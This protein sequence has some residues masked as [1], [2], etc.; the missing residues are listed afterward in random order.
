MSPHSL[1]VSASALVEHNPWSVLLSLQ[2]AGQSIFEVDAFAV[3]VAQAIADERKAASKAPILRTAEMVEMMRPRLQAECKAM[4]ADAPDRLRLILE[5]L[6]APGRLLRVIE[7][8]AAT[9]DLIMVR[10]TV[11]LDAVHWCSQLLAAFINDL[12]QADRTF[13]A[14]CKS[15]SQILEA[16][17]CVD[18]CIDMADVTIIKQLLVKTLE[19]C[20]EDVSGHIC[21]PCLLPSPPA[22]DV[23]TSTANLIGCGRRFVCVGSMLEFIPPSIF[24]TVAVRARTLHTLAEVFCSRVVLKLESQGMVVRLEQRGTRCIELA[25]LA[26][27]GKVAIVAV[28]N[29]EAWRWIELIRDVLRDKAPGLAVVERS[30][31]YECIARCK[32]E[33]SEH[34]TPGEHRAVS[35]SAAPIHCRQCR[36]VLELDRLSCLPRSPAESWHRDHLA[37]HHAHNRGAASTVARRHLGA[38]SSAVLPANCRWKAFISHHQAAC[39]GFVKALR[40][41][42]EAELQRRGVPLWQMWT[43]MTETADEAGMRNGIELSECFIMFIT[44][45]M[46]E[47]HSCQMEIRWALELR[48]QVLVVYHTDP[49]EGHGNPDFGFY[50]NLIKRA[51]PCEDDHQWLLKGVAVPYDQRGGYDTVMVSDILKQMPRAQVEPVVEIV[52]VDPSVRH[53]GEDGE[54]VPEDQCKWAAFVS[55]HQ[56]ACSHQVLWLGLIIESRLKEQGK[57]LT[58]VWIDKNERATIHGMQEGVRLSRHFILFLTKEV[59]SR[60]FC[61][62]EISNA[63]KY[64]KNVILVYQTDERYGGVPGPFFDFYGKELKKCFPNEEDW[65]WLMKNSYVQFYDRAEHVDVMLHSR[66]CE[67]GILD[68]MQLEQAFVAPLATPPVPV[69]PATKRKREDCAIEALFEEWR[70]SAYT[71]MFVAE[72]YTFERDLLEASKKD[73][74]ALM[75]NMKPADSKRLRRNLDEMAAER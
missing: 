31:C 61:L 49:R 35:P 28:L 12:S 73:L 56:V 69:Q 59:L 46:L 23:A 57:R 39:G 5:D 19:V 62:E 58:R 13:D 48:K 17:V 29:D 2:V 74:K 7:D 41:L 71:Q 10:G 6:A 44:T 25:V 14:A 42:L 52:P 66:R 9:G 38:E 34:D 53:L 33:P 37:R 75:T 51:F 65:K 68:Q 55:H 63:L 3:K 67:N 21:F 60:K 1:E 16:C 4:L 27:A 8:L 40:L 72:G 47:R 22:N 20:F 54:D 36:N 24:N 32:A 30:P 26:D 45:K 43:D 50:I 70:L 11:V 18:I 15:D 64:R